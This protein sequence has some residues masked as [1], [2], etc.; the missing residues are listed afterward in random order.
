MAN[1]VKLKTAKRTAAHLAVAH[2][3]KDFKKMITSA[4]L[5]G[6]IPILEKVTERVMD[7]KVLDRKH[8]LMAIV[9]LNIARLLHLP[10]NAKHVIQLFKKI[11][12][13]VK[14]TNVPLTQVKRVVTHAKVNSIKLLLLTKTKA[15]T[16]KFKSE[17][18]AKLNNVVYILAAKNVTHV[19]LVL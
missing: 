4:K 2:V 8:I 9:S 16:N 14:H 3:S 12:V 1:S 13:L 7:A 18:N 17:A 19:T 6:A 11:K 5:R 15:K 10:S